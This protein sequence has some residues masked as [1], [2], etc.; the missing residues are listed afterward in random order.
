MATTWGKVQEKVFTR[1][2]NTHL[3]ERDLSITGLLDGS[4][5]DGIM[6]WNLLEEISGK[7]LTKIDF[8]PKMRI[9]KINN[10]GTSI[11]FVNDEGI[12]LVGIGAENI[13]DRD[14][15]QVMG[16]IWTLIL[17]WHVAKKGGNSKAAKRELIDWL[18]SVGIPCT[19]LD[20]DWT[21][22]DYICRLVN[23][24]RPNLVKP[25]GDPLDDTEAAIESSLNQ[26]GIPKVVD[27]SDLV[28]D[29]PDEL[30]NM[31]Y[32]SYFR[33]KYMDAKNLV[34]VVDSTIPK[35]SSV[36]AP[37]EF[38]IEFLQG[39][40]REEFQP[41]LTSPVLNSEGDVIGNAE[42][43]AHPQ[44]PNFSIVSF[45]PTSTGKQ[46]VDVQ[47]SGISVQGSPVFLNAGVVPKVTL[48]VP[49]KLTGTVGIPVNIP[50]DTENVTPSMLSGCVVLDPAG[51]PVGNSSVKGSGNSYQ[52]TFT[53]L[54]KGK[55]VAH[56]KL[57]GAEVPGSPVEIQ[58]VA[59]PNVTVP[60]NLE[61]A[62]VKVPYKFHL[63]A[64][65]VK[66]EN[67]RVNISDPSGKK[68][69]AKVIPDGDGFSVN[70]T[71]NEKGKFKVDLALSG[72]PVEGAPLYITAKNPPKLEINGP[73]FRNDAVVDV[74]Y[75][76][77]LD[78]ENVLPEQIEVVISDPKGNKV[79]AKLTPKGDNGF[80]LDFTPRVPG[81]HN[82]AVKLDGNE[83]PGSPITVDVQPKPWA[84]VA[85]VGDVGNALVHVPFEF[86]IETINV[87]P[88]QLSVKIVGPD[89]RPVSDTK[90]TPN[91]G[92]KGYTVGFTPQVPGQ[93]IATVNL[94]G[95]EIEGSPVK[96]I[97]KH[98]PQIS[99]RGDKFRDDAIVDDPYKVILDS[100]NVNPDQ[101][102]IVVTDPTGKKLPTKISPIGSSG[103]NVDFTP[104]VPGNHTFA[105]KLDGKEVEGSPITIKASER[106]FAKINL[107][108]C[109]DAVVDVPYVI[110]IDTINVRPDDLVATV[111]DP[112]GR[113]VDVDVRPRKDGTGYNAHFTPRIPGKFKATALLNNEPCDGSPAIILAHPKP[114]VTLRGDKY[115]DDAI[116]DDPY[117][118]IADAVNVQPDQ[119]SLTVTDPTGKRVPAKLT[120]NADGTQYDIDFTP[121]VPGHHQ[122]R[123]NLDGKEVEG[124]PITVNAQP[125]P[126][127]TVNARDAGDA[128]VNVEYS[129]PIDTVN[130][131]PE[132]LHVTVK[133]PLGKPVHTV[134]VPP[135][136]G[137]NRYN[138]KF[139]P[140]IKGKF[141]ATVNLD[142][143]DV[144]GSPITILAKPKPSVQLIDTPKIAVAGSPC[145]I[146]LAV[147]EFSPKDIS[148]AI[149]DAAKFTYP[150][151]EIAIKVDNSRR[152][153]NVDPDKEII[154]VVFTP[155]EPIKHVVRLFCSGKEVDGS[156]INVKVVPKPSIDPLL[157]NE[158]GTLGTNFV[159]QKIV[160]ENISPDEITV[161]MYDP[162]GKNIG[163]AAVKDN[164]DTTF[165]ISSVFHHVGRHTA[166]ILY[167][168]NSVSPP[169]S[170]LVV[171]AEGRWGTVGEEFR[172]PI[173]VR[174]FQPN[175][176][177]FKVSHKDS[178]HIYK[179]TT[180]Q[181]SAQSDAKYDIVFVPDFPGKHVIEMSLQG[182]IL[183]GTP[184]EV[185]VVSPPLVTLLTPDH[186]D[187]YLVDIGATTPFARISVAS[188]VQISS[189]EVVIST[190]AGKTVGKG[191]I[192]DRGDST[193]NLCWTPSSP[194]NYIANVKLN[195]LLV[196]GPITFKVL[197]C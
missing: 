40:K 113:P 71:P 36:G 99:I 161:V 75:K 180:I 197:R 124:S 92:N 167:N 85:L 130:V 154:S 83:V 170:F 32:L 190:E 53:P 100:V 165:D 134:L 122:V 104:K 54:Q 68:V 61:D 110:P 163:K 157:E 81:H 133:D 13:I 141:T 10:L 18:N 50:M 33:D 125:R 186:N 120:P 112:K 93:F 98:K 148:A 176:L 1:W 171:P 79:P 88:E 174:N 22:G 119:L 76:I 37:F 95:S 187:E 80:D 41:K 58:V 11:N 49:S 149:Q 5:D 156:P 126:R 147:E 52:L 101:L 17:R 178:N 4:L 44:K 12:K 90:V 3:D 26:F 142:G 150:N 118:I 177:S 136:A 60:K 151:S 146:L 35:S 66:P 31:T 84:R 152:P 158:V 39:A 107:S 69:D 143:G 45:V 193:W 135:V 94:D 169:F 192:V 102:Q 65:N 14:V 181:D 63:E 129:L 166:E 9:H 189:L 114:S 153:P 74:P 139:T 27:A 15:Q 103:F 185:D 164:E 70:F 188:S 78:S 159:F 87:K 25:T 64:E 7:K 121:H 30:V 127:A 73:K 6:L 21:N 82:V 46:C 67:L 57:D 138:A 128:T 140:K 34:R 115:R 195:D 109:P 160:V 168:G 42:I 59:K 89:G 175:Q 105:V 179:N 191:S 116:V 20:K 183:P 28:S 137:G 91:K 96:I 29:N 173:Q 8:N 72:E 86:P 16:L 62:I 111:H 43:K 56:V 38:Q 24:L 48:R 97:A 172:L 51:K 182:K 184:L 106:P 132:N 145:A 108:N 2:A 123:L 155:R 47:L 19:N 194:G 55:H 23:V 117:K 196:C 131:K 144:E 162:N 77:H